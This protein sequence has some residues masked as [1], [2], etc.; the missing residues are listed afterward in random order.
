MLNPNLYVGFSC[1]DGLLARAI[2]WFTGGNVNHAFLAWEDAHLGWVVLGANEN[3]VTLDTL[4]NFKKGRS[5]VHTYR[6]INGTLWSGLEKLRA[7]LNVRYNIGG[8]AGMS[9]VELARRFHQS[10]PNPGNNRKELFCSEFAIEVIR[11][12]H[13]SILTNYIASTVDPALLDSTLAHDIDFIQE[14]IG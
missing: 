14:T 8:L 1:S 12:A 2:L 10:I 5:I 4:D 13:Y 7:D 11:A 6:P 9:I 3:G